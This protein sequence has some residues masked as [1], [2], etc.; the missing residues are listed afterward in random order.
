MRN[1]FNFILE[2]EI[3]T[4]DCSSTLLALISIDNEY[5]TLIC[6]GL[7]EKFKNSENAIK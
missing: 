1:V 4:H 2:G 3:S 7:L 5:Y 6:N